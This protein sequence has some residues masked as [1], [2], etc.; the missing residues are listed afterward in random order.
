[1]LNQLVLVGRIKKV[2]DN[3]I[4]LSI[5][6]NYKNNEGIYETDLIPII[7]PESILEKSKEYCKIDDV[8]GVK[9]R[10]E[11]KEGN[12]IVIA[13]KMTFLSSNQRDRLCK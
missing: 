7:L 9:G 12:I 11:T 13:E 8:V 3:T 1:M 4:T 2:E 5:P 6:R 10:L